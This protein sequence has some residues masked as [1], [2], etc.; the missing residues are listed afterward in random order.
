[1]ASAWDEVFADEQSAPAAPVQPSTGS[2][3]DALDTRDVLSRL[4]VVGGM[5]EV[6]FTATFGVGFDD[7][8]VARLAREGSVTIDPLGGIDLVAENRA[9]TVTLGDGRVAH[10]PLTDADSRAARLILARLHT[11][12]TVAVSDIY[13]MVMPPNADAAISALDADGLLV[14]ESVPGDNAPRAV[15]RRTIVPRITAAEANA[16]LSDASEPLPVT[17]DPFREKAEFPA[18]AVNA[19][20]EQF[21]KYKDTHPGWE[22]VYSLVESSAKDGLYFEK[23]G[24]GELQNALTAAGWTEPNPDRHGFYR[25]RSP[26]DDGIRREIGATWFRRTYGDNSA[27]AP[28]NVDELRTAVETQGF[29]QV[30]RA[31]AKIVHRLAERADT[32][33]RIADQFTVTDDDGNVVID[34]SE[35]VAWATLRMKGAVITHTNNG[36][37][38]LPY[39]N[40]PKTVAEKKRRAEQAEAERIAKEA[41]QA[42]AERVAQ[43]AERVAQE[44]TTVPATRTPATVPDGVATREDISRVERKV[45][46]LTEGM[47]QTYTA[48]RELNDALVARTANR[49]GAT[50]ENVAVRILEILHHEGRALTKSQMR[51]GVSKARRHLMQPALKYLTEIGAIEYVGNAYYQIIDPSKMGVSYKELEDGYAE[52]ARYSSGSKKAMTTRLAKGAERLRE[53]AGSEFRARNP[54]AYEGAERLR[55]PEVVG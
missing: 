29:D 4:W 44:A 46:I 33:E 38:L 3:W 34:G 17:T 22:F 39:G 12:Q 16:V 48:A 47:A 45:E 53:L 40:R 43:E 55:Q 49:R 32:L 11:D 13:E 24:F 30:R 14:Q 15:V 18:A 37:S 7:P 2:A 54:R 21:G 8:E 26:I 6:T 42:E 1:M 41:E 25:F 52:S 20:D 5:D 28:D 19:W 31:S 27:A 35:V 23:S 10:E 36:W 51:D 50:L 9:R